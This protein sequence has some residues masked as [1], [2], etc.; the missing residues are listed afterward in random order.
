ML[1]TT[2]DILFFVLNFLRVRWNAHNQLE[3][4]HKI[5]PKSFFSDYIQQ[6]YIRL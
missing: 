6:I 2:N 5:Y 1:N 3:K 4:K